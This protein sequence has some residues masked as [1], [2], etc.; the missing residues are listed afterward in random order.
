MKATL[1]AVCAIAVL[2]IADCAGGKTER[3]TAI[4]VGREYIPAHTTYATDSKGHSTTHY[5]PADYTL[6]V[7]QAGQTKRIDTNQN[8]YYF[9]REGQPI[10]YSQR[11]GCLSHTAW[12]SSYYR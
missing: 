2:F 3:V 12:L 4:V 8:G 11:R 7:E 6:I 1:F 5:T 9:V 10:T